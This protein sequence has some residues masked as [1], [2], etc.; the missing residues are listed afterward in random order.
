MVSCSIES[1]ETYL[2][3]QWL[4]IHLPNSGDV[5]LIPGG[6]TKIPHIAGQ[7]R[8]CIATGEVHRPQ[9]R[10]LPSTLQERAS[11]AK[12]RNKSLVFLF[13]KKRYI[14]QN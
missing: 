6:R 10:R 2:L 3:V 11:T 14:L 8:P 1:L 4:R 7:L 13:L 12:I 9:L 5:G